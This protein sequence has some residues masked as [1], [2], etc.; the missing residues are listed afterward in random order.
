MGEGLDNTISEGTSI[1]PVQNGIKMDNDRSVSG[2][3]ETA[4]AS[5]YDLHLCCDV[6]LLMV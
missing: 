1:S 3:T 5:V 2:E 6:A 4:I